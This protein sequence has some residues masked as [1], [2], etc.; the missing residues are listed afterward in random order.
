MKTTSVS[1]ATNTALTKRRGALIE[2]LGQLDLLINVTNKQMKQALTAGE[3]ESYQWSMPRN[4]KTSLRPSNYRLLQQYGQ[5]LREADVL[6]ARAES[7]PR[8]EKCGMKSLA[9]QL[10]YRKAEAAY[11]SAYE[12]LEQLGSVCEFFDRD[13]PAMTGGWPAP[14]PESA[15]RLIGSRSQYALK[16]FYAVKV[17]SMK[18][19]RSFL[20]ASLQQLDDPQDLTETDFCDIGLGETTI[21]RSG[22]HN[23]SFRQRW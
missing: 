15:P 3:F 20:Q 10:K 8:A 11:E 23:H 4:P 14:E 7:A 1:A 19:K 2:L 17:E 18:L 9:R 12:T 22:H 6:Y 16:D 5:K 13:V 21:K